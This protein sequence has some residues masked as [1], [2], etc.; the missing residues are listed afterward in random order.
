MVKRVFLQ[1]SCE[2]TGISS[3]TLYIACQLIG[4]NSPLKFFCA[5]KKTCLGV[6]N[7]FGNNVNEDG[8]KFS[9][10]IYV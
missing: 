1:L 9:V 4:L 5:K 7:A 3:F 6:S 10:I 8:S 2:E